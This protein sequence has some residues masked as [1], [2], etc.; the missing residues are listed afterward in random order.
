MKQVPRADAICPVSGK[1]IM[2]K[3]VAKS[4]AKRVA[5]NSTRYKLAGAPPVDAYKCTAC[6]GWHV[7][8]RPKGRRP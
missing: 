4:T 2:S 6:K 5:K 8:K 3:S 7:G 1:A